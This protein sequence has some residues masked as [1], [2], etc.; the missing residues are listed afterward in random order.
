M[1]VTSRYPLDDTTPLDLFDLADARS[2]IATAEAVLR[3]V[4]QLDQPMG[5]QP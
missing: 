2:A 1:T 3:W 4:E 5:H